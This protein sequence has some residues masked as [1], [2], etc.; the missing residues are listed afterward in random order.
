MQ[1]EPDNGLARNSFHSTVV[2]M[3]CIATLGSEHHRGP[4]LRMT[5]FV[6]PDPPGLSGPSDR[7]CLCTF[8]VPFCKQG[9]LTRPLKLT[10]AAELRSAGQPRAAVPTCLLFILHIHVLGVDYTFVL[11]LAPPVGIRL[12]TC[13]CGWA[14]PRRTLW[15]CRLVHLLGQL[16]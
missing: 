2:R 15:L 1:F 7:C 10:T 9:A 12:R 6:I 3:P 4:S 8:G 16:V 13:P 5:V 14:C 11:F